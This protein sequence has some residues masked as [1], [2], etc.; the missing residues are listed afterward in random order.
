MIGRTDDESE[1]VIAGITL[2]S[3]LE[4]RRQLMDTARWNI[5]KKLWLIFAIL[6]AFLTVIPTALFTV[7]RSVGT[8]AVLILM[9]VGVIVSLVSGQIHRRI[10]AVIQLLEEKDILKEDSTSKDKNSPQA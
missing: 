1:K 5:G 9:W 3:R 2:R 10:D 7:E 4:R 6:A 8:L